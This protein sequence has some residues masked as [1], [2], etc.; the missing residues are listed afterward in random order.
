VLTQE[1]RNLL[2][3][4]SGIST[5]AIIEYPITPVMPQDKS[6][7]AF[8]DL[9][10]IEEPFEKF[11]SYFMNEMLSVIEFFNE[12]Q[13]ELRDGI[14]NISGTDGS[15]QY[16]TTD[17]SIIEKKFYIPP[18][19]FEAMKNAENVMTFELSKEQLQKVNKL[20]GLLKLNQIVMDFS[21][22][23]LKFLITNFSDFGNYQTPANLNVE[24]TGIEKH[25]TIVV[26][27]RNFQMLPADDY[28]GRVIISPKGNLS[29]LM[30][31]KTKPITYMVNI[32]K[33]KEA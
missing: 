12:P 33:Q 32:L 24:C 14:L 7:I 13:I 20:S 5:A 22:D 28:D 15:C 19:K 29:I 11:G 10:G 2:K 9:T 17:V 1:T 8:V 18:A 31:S 25:Y 4:V 27:T 26:D 3:T 16:E 30:K 21:G 6:V 23:N